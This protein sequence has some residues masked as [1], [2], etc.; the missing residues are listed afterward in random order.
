MNRTSGTLRARLWLGFLAVVILGSGSAWAQVA[1]TASLAG[2]VADSSGAVVPGASVT[3][4]NRGTQFTRTST[5]GANGRFLLTLLPIGSY[6][7]EAS[8]PGFATYQQTGITLNVDTTHSLN[9]E[10]SVG[11]VLEVVTVTSEAPMTA[12]ESGTLSQVVNTRAVEDLPLNG[13]NVA[14]MVYLVPGIVYGTRTSRAGYANTEEAL[15]ISANGARGS[16]VGYKLDGGTHSDVI[17]RNN[18]IFPNP[19]AI[20]EFS[21]QTSNYNAEYGNSAG[22]IVNVVTKSGTNEFHGAAFNFLRNGSMNARNFFARAHDNLKRNQFGATL[23]GPV[24]ANKLFFFG[25]Y[26]GYR[27]KNTSLS[28][29]AFVPSLEKRQGDFSALRKQLKNPFTGE[30]FPNNRIPE[31]L[32]TPASVGLLEF[33][34]PP[35]SPDGRVLFARPDDRGN[36]Q[37]LGKLDYNR[38][39][40]MI[41][42][43]FFHVRH[44]EDGWDGDNTLLNSRM[45]QLQTTKSFTGRWTWTA[46]PNLVNT[47]IAKTLFLDS[48]NIRTTPFDLTDFGVNVAP[49]APERRALLLRITG[50]G[51]WGSGSGPPGSNWIR[52]NHEFSNTVSYIKGKHSIQFGAEFVPRIKFESNTGFRQA[53]SIDF[54]GRATG[55]GFAD[56]LTGR[57]ARFRQS[58]G[59][60]KD[61]RGFEMS[62]YVQD[63]FNVARDFS[64][65]VGLRWD[66]WWPY[67]DELGQVTGFRPGLQS[68]R[69]GNAP[70]GLVFAGDRNFPEAGT[71]SNLL[72]L[73]PRFGFAWNVG[74]KNRT[75]VRGGYG[76]F[77][78]RLPGV[79][80]NNFVEAAPFSP[81][82][83]LRDVDFMDPYG[84][85]GVR[86]PFPEAFAPYTP[87]SDVTF[88]S[89]GNNFTIRPD[90]K[91][92]YIQ[93]WNL[94]VERQLVADLLLRTAYV[95]SKGTRLVSTDQLNPAIFG[96]GATLGNTNRRRPLY[97]DFASLVQLGS[98]YFSTYHS[99]Q[100]SLE[101][102]YR[103]NLSFLTF[104]TFSK[105]I[106]QDS[107]DPQFNQPH[108]PFDRSANRGLSAYNVPHNFRQSFIWDL[109]RLAGQNAFMRH[110]AGGWSLAGI[111]TWQSGNP[112][113]IRT[114]RDRSLAGTNDDRPDLLAGISPFLPS[115][116][117][118]AEV[119]QEY[120]NTDAFTL[121]P[122]GTFGTTPRNLIHAPGDFKVDVSLQK[123]IHLSEGHRLQFRAEFFNMLNNVNLGS[124]QRTMVNRRFGRITSAGSP[125]IVQLGL[126]YVF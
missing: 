50:Y 94:T 82:F 7:L 102:R 2:T 114:G 35:Q 29:T 36:N 68:E 67:T 73:A 64:L 79:M 5:T 45:A 93:Q 80:Y 11:E 63:K 23:G 46:S 76:V 92:G 77:F 70:P 90:F 19:D 121:N 42:G 37:Y 51:G 97:P 122:L 34:P 75:S 43:S 55:D 118:R 4:T 119:I 25:S 125:R 111:W 6:S 60:A 103:D 9:V 87:P 107:R 72:N 12:T 27:I 106:D 101:K 95:G 105:S 113:R 31:V 100:V 88:A 32:F 21:V 10:L 28:N 48:F 40:H 58:G 110:V 53:P 117:P 30:L 112:I 123:Q 99:L 69:F 39:L 61:M 86:D 8:A 16:E 116:R 74:G 24:L 56:F 13:R 57:V 83:E 20:Q 91:T 98:D 89:V 71:N 126:K 18:A 3:V 33:L 1:P 17:W 96:A 14:S 66:P 85:K 81:S 41:S 59:K 26:Q 104:Y 65:N 47:F 78:S 49:T 38:G 22:A 52:Q 44:T 108:N 62:L 84:S 109:P 120:F 15:A 115:N 124:P 54:S